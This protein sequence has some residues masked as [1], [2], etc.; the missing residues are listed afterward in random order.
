MKFEFLEHTADVKFRAFGKDLNE[1][2]ES[3]ALAFSEIV[4]KGQKVKSVRKKNIE[5]EAED[6]K[7]L[8]YSFLDELVFL[9]DAEGF[10]VCSGEIKIDGN[11]LSAEL[12][13]DDSKNYSGLEHVKAATYADMEVYEKN[14]MWIVQAV[15]DV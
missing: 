13:G 11:S 2:F 7:S 6:K 12:S 9:F 5:I 10:L 8:L 14:K 4:A 3:S 1:A 15:L